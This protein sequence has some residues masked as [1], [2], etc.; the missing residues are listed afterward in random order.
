MGVLHNQIDV[1]LFVYVVEK[2]K[3]GSKSEHPYRCEY[4]KAGDDPTERRFR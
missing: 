2:R 3:G 4:T 1:R